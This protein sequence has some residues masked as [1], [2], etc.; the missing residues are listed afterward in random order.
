M[1]LKHSIITAALSAC[2]VCLSGLEGI[3][4]KSFK[5]EPFSISSPLVKKSHRHKSQTKKK[6][7]IS[8][9]GTDN[10]DTSDTGGLIPFP[11]TT[12][13]SGFWFPQNSSTTFTIPASGRYN[14]SL[15]MQHMHIDAPGPGTIFTFFLVD[16]QPLPNGFLELDENEIIGA[17]IIPRFNISRLVNLRKGQQL[18]VMIMAQNGTDLEIEATDP[19][20]LGQ[21][22]RALSIEKID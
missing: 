11:V 3:E 22:N 19:P 2:I 8:S 4:V 6:F 13:K 14:L 18:S 7:Y 12:V 1:I 15:N 21:S 10:W 20:F 16:G 17:S 5:P 9:Y